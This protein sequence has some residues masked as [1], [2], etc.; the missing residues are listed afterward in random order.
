MAENVGLGHCADLLES[1]LLGAPVDLGVSK[2]HSFHLKILSMW[3]TR[4]SN[5]VSYLL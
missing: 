5:L 1:D 3:I 4:S 2:N